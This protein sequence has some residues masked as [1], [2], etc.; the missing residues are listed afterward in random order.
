MASSVEDYIEGIKRCL[1]EISRAEVEGVVK[2]IGDA[3][4][5]QKRLFV[6]GNGGSASTS[7][8]FA[9]D[10]G[11][12]TGTAL[13]SKTMSLPVLSLTDNVALMTAIANDIGYS[14]IF[15]EQ[16]ASLLSKGDVVIGISASGNS[17]NV[18]EAIEYAKSR[19]AMTIGICGFGGGK[20]A[21]TAD[22]ALIF[23]AK[24]YGQVEDIHLC[25]AH[26]LSYLLREKMAGV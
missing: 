6:F 24:D 26:M 18:L 21:Q 19:G 3:F 22:R 20:L 9:C 10:L 8:H 4:K 15:K 12:G 11:K 14:S 7:S 2:A 13:D 1:S 23:S 16:L 5:W 25:L 17:P